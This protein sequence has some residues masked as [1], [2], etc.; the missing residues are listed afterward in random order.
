V[1]D[2][3]ALFRL[4]VWVYRDQQAHRLLVRPADWF[5]WA[6]ETSAGLDDLPRPCVAPEAAT[7]HSA[8]LGLP[9]RPPKPSLSSITQRL[10]RPQSH[11][12]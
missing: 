7:V 3:D 11:P 5:L 6:V 9:A 4:L 12:A 2:F 8:V 1:M 10:M